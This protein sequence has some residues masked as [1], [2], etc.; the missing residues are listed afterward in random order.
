MQTDKISAVLTGDSRQPM[1]PPNVVDRILQLSSEGWGKRRIAKELGISP[2]TVKHYRRQGKWL[3]Y[4]IPKRIK[5]LEA[6]DVWLEEM[7]NLHKGNAEVIRQELVRQHN[8]QANL[9]TIERAVKPFRQRAFASAKATVRFETPPGKQMQI[10]FGSITIKIAG[11]LKR[12]HFFAAVLGFSRRQYIR[13]FMHERQSAWFEGLEGAFHHFG[14]ITQEVLLDNPKALV[15]S[16]NPLTREVVFNERLHTFASYWKF[17]PKACAPYRARTKGKDENTV[18]YFKYNAI[19]GREFSSW[20]ALEEHIAWWMKDIS[21]LRIHGTTGEKPIDR[22]QREE[23][24]VLQSLNGKPP[25]HLGRELQRSVHTDACIELDTNFYSVPW[26]LIK[27]EVTV[28]LS[29]TAVRIF[30]N[31]VEVARHPE[32]VGERQRSINPE[33]LKGIVGAN[34]CAKAPIL[35][36]SSKPAE[37]LR[38][39]A[40]YEV[41]AGGGWL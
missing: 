20:E 21:D 32:C 18:K 13:A 24:A 28:Q 5:K 16:H 34:W 19:A 22:F 10:D 36:V 17:K 25:F 6:L 35:N 33:H 8:M 12:I 41:V 30:H 37:L 29:G 27:S 9:R 40:E 3:P 11:E 14:G 26:H 38:P 31:A 1:E 23:A 39:L 4:D 2:N 15:I 7:F